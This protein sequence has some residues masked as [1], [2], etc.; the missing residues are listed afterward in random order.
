MCSEKG[1]QSKEC[2]YLKKG[3]KVLKELR[4][5]KKLGQHFLNDCRIGYLF[6]STLSDMD[7]GSCLEIGAGIGLLTRF[8]AKACK[9]VLACEA[10][11]RL[12]PYL[13]R[14]TK[15]L[16]NVYITACDGVSLL[17]NG[18]RCKILV[19]NTP[20]NISALLLTSFIKSNMKAALLMLQKE[21]ADKLLAKPGDRNY[22]RISAFVR[23]FTNVKKINDF[24]P[25]S[26]TPEPS[27]SSS[28]VI[29][30]R[31]VAWNNDWLL[32]E[33][34]LRHLFPYR[35][36]L[37]A[38]VFSKYLLSIGAKIEDNLTFLKEKRVYELSIS[39]LLRMYETIKRF[40]A[41]ISRL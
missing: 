40:R 37:A 31:K 15:D 19:S 32:Y 20:Y 9:R 41:Q 25:S 12:L 35:R 3:A 16:Y 36:K 10:D 14:L 17:S 11:L 7:A 24:L 22:G 29:L 27:V 30:K 28:L 26:F 34:M 6:A 4:P 21:V 5:I 39:D 38:K 13:R 2:L 33:D 8:I 23:T 18:C 1:W